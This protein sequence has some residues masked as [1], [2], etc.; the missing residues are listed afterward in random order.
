MTHDI[1]YQAP[2]LLHTTNDEKLGGD[3]GRRLN[4]CTYACYTILSCKCAECLSARL[5]TMKCSQFTYYWTCAQGTLRMR[6]TYL[7]FVD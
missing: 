2:L 3:L 6:F 1:M 7:D 4:L 5:V